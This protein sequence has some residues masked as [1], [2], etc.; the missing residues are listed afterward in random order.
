MSIIL[1][2]IMGYELCKKIKSKMLFGDIPIYYITVISE[3][4]V[5]KKIEETKAD[6]YFL[7]PFNFSNFESILRQLKTY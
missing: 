5:S 1:N 6:G 7:K 3:A 2:D 4:E